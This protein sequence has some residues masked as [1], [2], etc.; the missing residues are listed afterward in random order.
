MS[1]TN[2]KVD[3]VPDHGEVELSPAQRAKAEE[4]LK[5]VIRLQPIKDAEEEPILAVAL[6]LTGVMLLLGTIH[7]G[8][9]SSERALAVEKAEGKTH[10]AAMNAKLAAAGLARLQARVF[11]QGA[12]A[13][14]ESN[15]ELVAGNSAAQQMLDKVLG[16]VST[17]GMPDD[18]C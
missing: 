7:R 17:E 13:F 1:G 5:K 9:V 14:L 16:H 11:D 10:P 2:E 6:N 4:G 8:I 3:S 18:S 15:P 12:K